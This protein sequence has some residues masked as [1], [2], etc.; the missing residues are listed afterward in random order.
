M[1]VHNLDEA[2]YE[3]RENG[4]ESPRPLVANKFFDTKHNSS[5]ILSKLKAFRSSATEESKVELEYH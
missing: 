3:E 5:A 1:K 4:Q 2:E